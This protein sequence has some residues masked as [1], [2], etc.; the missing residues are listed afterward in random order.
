MFALLLFPQDFPQVNLL[1]FNLALQDVA[2]ASS[3]AFFEAEFFCFA[4]SL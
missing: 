3:A 2:S 4:S 1:R